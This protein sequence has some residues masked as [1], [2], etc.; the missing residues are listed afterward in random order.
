M[1]D[2]TIVTF[3]KICATPVLLSM[4]VVALRS[5]NGEEAAV[6]RDLRSLYLSAT[7]K[8]LAAR[9]AHLSNFGWALFTLASPIAVTG[10]TQLMTDRKFTGYVYLLLPPFMLLIP[11]YALVSTTPCTRLLSPSC[12]R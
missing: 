8:V 10:I 7:R 9:A 2:R 5:G 6:P 4:L 3:E 1:L 12:A 11:L